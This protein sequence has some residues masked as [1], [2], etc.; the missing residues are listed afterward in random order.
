MG[1]ERF[2]HRFATLLLEPSTTQSHIVTKDTLLECP[3]WVR[4]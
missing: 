4:Q 2:L 3:A 1:G